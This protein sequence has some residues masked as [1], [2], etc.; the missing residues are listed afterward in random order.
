MIN[1]IITQGDDIIH[2]TNSLENAKEICEKYPPAKRPS[3]ILS[4]WKLEKEYK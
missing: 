3:Q 2:N 4:I 1:Y